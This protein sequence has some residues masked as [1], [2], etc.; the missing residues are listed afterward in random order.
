ML[1]Y[2]TN[3]SDMLKPVRNLIF[4]LIVG[5]QKCRKKKTNIQSGFFCCVSSI[6]FA[7]SYYKLTLKSKN[8][9]PTLQYQTSYMRK[10]LLA[11]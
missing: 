10:I 1:C 2:M 7:G 6:H 3:I 11:T 9:V 5:L 8:L 4:F